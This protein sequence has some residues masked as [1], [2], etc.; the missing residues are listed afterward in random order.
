MNR[1]RRAW[2]LVSLLASS[3]L[4]IHAAGKKPAP[5]AAPRKL[6]ALRWSSAGWIPGMFCTKFDEPADPH[7]W[8]DNFL[9]STR[10]LGL[11]WSNRG[12]IDAMVCTK[13]DEGS[14]PDG[15]S[16]NYL[17][18]PRDY[19]FRW[20]MNGPLDAMQCLQISEPADPHAWNDNFLC[21]PAAGDGPLNAV[22]SPPQTRTHVI[23]IIRAIHDYQS[24][25]EIGQGKREENFDSIGCK[26]KVGVDPDRNW[27]AT[28]QLTSDEFFA[29]NKQTF[30]LIFID[31]L[32]HADQVE[33]DIANSLKILNPGGT[34]VMHDCNPTSVEQQ[35]VPRPSD[36]VDWKGSVWKAWVKFRATRDDLRMY[37]INVDAGCGVITRGK[38]TKVKL[39]A[40]LTYE[41]LDAH[42]KEWLNLIE[43]DDFL[44]SLASQ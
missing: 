8:D 31:G 22:I 25:L 44:K 42:R 10:D 2:L 17:C 11:R 34:I 4:P 1:F 6:E 5:P 35:M 21:W 7:G 13:I 41:A 12:P 27:N 23:N 38:Q 24:Y 36:Q 3:S 15:W 39:P 26:I 32:H 33:R 20:S 9:C 40:K 30:D 37:V 18:A 29:Q 28:F 14:D 43:V 16:D 19:G